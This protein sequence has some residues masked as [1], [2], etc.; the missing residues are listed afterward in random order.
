MIVKNSFLF[1][2]SIITKGLLNFVIIAVFT[3][4]LPADAFG[5]Y[6]IAIAL[7]GFADVFGFMW[8][9]QALM[10]H[11]TDDKTEGDAAYLTNITMLY[12]A[13]ALTVSIIGLILPTPQGLIWQ[14]IGILAAAEALSNL[15]VLIARL[16][17]NLKLFFV[18][19]LVKP[20]VALGLG[21]ALI[22]YGWGAS[23]ALWALLAGCGIAALIGLCLAR[24]FK[25]LAP[26]HVNKQ[27]MRAIAVFSLPLVATLSIQSAIQ[28]TD[29]VLLETLIG[30]DITGLYAAAQDIPAKLLIIGVS[31]VH[32]AAY[33]LIVKAFER[34]D[35]NECRT[36]LIHH[37]ACLWGILCPSALALAVLSAP[38]A[39]LFL[40]AEFRP[41]AVQYMPVFAAIAVLNALIQY[42]WMLAFN[43]S[44]QT[45]MMIAPF[46]LSLVINA[47]AGWALIPQLGANGA[48]LG[49]ALSYGSLLMAAIVLGRR[50]FSLPL[51]VM[52]LAKITLAAMVMAL[53]L[54]ILKPGNG[55]AALIAAILIGGAVYG[56]ALW[57][58]NPLD[59]RRAIKGKL[60]TA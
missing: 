31:A 24:D 49:S 33:P 52:P 23:G 46:A 22:H 26:R 27:T 21:A 39:N 59:L 57:L 42:Y 50:V 53:V 40:G 30:G 16:R 45:L 9:R 7:V 5:D 54:Y 20:L 32:M 41:F 38:L 25:T 43:L 36:R 1:G 4:M 17:L 37:A 6:A 2:I 48:I 14:C 13:A 15:A 47:V 55:P 56:G 12:S 51:P 11:M 58:C 60:C 18:L 19:N 29:R 28:T 35:M 10:R 44:R 34:G 3:R 8:L